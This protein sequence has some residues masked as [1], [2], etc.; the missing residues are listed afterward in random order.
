MA[1]RVSYRVKMLGN[2]YYLEVGVGTCNQVILGDE[3]NYRVLRNI[4]IEEVRN[5][6]FLSYL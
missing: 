4:F 2:M 5:N 3:R 6:G 1:R